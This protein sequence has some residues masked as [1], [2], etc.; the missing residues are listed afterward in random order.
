[1]GRVVNDYPKDG[2]FTD[3]WVYKEV[4]GK[5]ARTEMYRV[6]QRVNAFQYET[7]RDGNPDYVSVWGYKAIE[8]QLIAAPRYCGNCD[9]LCP[10]GD[11]LCF[12]CRRD[13]QPRRIQ[14]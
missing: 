1:M 6:G 8:A 10:D 7:F 11:Y 14:P 5:Y 12:F 2:L 9:N 3:K 13:L 4:K